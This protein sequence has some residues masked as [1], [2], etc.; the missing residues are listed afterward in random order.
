MPLRRKEMA[1]ENPKKLQKTIDF[2]WDILY[3]KWVAG[4]LPAQ[5]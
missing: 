3:T 4:F 1:V 2:L 5:G